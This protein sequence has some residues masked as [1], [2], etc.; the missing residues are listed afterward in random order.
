MQV[1]L[2]LE[3]KDI[4]GINEPLV[5]DLDITLESKLVQSANI[6]TLKTQVA[7]ICLIPMP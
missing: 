3:N 7:D 6:Y 5:A 4:K 1:G 2:G